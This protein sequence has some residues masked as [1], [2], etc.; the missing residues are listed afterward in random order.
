M[1]QMRHSGAPGVSERAT[2]GIA[3]Q[4][5]PI[6]IILL[7]TGVFW[8]KPSIYTH[9]D[10]PRDAQ[11]RISKIHN[12]RVS[13]L[14]PMEIGGGNRYGI[15]SECLNPLQHGHHQHLHQHHLH[16][17]HLHVLISWKTWFWV[18]S[19]VFPRSIV[20]LCLDLSSDLLMD[21]VKDFVYGCITFCYLLYMM[22]LCTDAWVHTYVG[23]M[24]KVVTIACV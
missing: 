18:Q 14:L 8:P 2:R 24:H 13:S 17:L 15:A 19:I 1:L 5:R 10:L 21:M 6:G 11:M 22:V 4:G 16:H 23:G 12:K 20:S 3:P 7:R 9:V